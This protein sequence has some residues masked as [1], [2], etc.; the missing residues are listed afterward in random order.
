MSF[1]TLSP[2]SS[3]RPVLSRFLIDD[4]ENETGWWGLRVIII[5]EQGLY[6]CDK[7]NLKHLRGVKIFKSFISLITY[8]VI[9]MGVNIMKIYDRMMIY[10]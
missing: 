2:W 9:P 5:G 3:V 1:P 6:K 10:Y 4:I 7:I 8:P